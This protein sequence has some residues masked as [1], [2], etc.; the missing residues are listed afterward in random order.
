MRWC[1]AGRVCADPASYFGCRM[2]T[3]NPRSCRMNGFLE[4]GGGRGPITRAELCYFHATQQLDCDTPVHHITQSTQQFKTLEEYAEQ[5]AHHTPACLPGLASDLHAC[6]Y[7]TAL[8]AF[9]CLVL[10][11]FPPCV[12]LCLHCMMLVQ[13]CSSCVPLPVS[14]LARA[15]LRH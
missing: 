10:C 1:Q 8:H 13:L 4:Q 14:H 12:C 11:P 6:P 9:L 2:R 7:S 5:W 15:A 3:V